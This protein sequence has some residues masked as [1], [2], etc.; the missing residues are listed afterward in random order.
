M[1]NNIVDLNKYRHT[2]KPQI[3]AWIDYKE[4]EDLL[5][6][7]SMLSCV[8]SYP[9]IEVCYYTGELYGF[10]PELLK[11]I[12]SLVAYYQVTEVIGQESP[13]DAKCR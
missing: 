4:P 12:A 9:L 8:T 1:N 2:L 3:K 7:I 6:E 5:R 10:T 11:M 13:L